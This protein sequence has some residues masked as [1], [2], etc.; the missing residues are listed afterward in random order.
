VATV[1][2]VDLGEE[3]DGPTYL[4]F[5]L[6]RMGVEDGLRCVVQLTAPSIPKTLYAIALAMES[7][8]QHNSWSRLRTSNFLRSSYAVIQMQRMGL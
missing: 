6:D 2:Y 4:E 1:V 8:A 7:R 3:L 5:S